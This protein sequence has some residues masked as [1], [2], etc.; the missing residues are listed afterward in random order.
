MGIKKHELKKKEN[1]GGRRHGSG[2]PKKTP[3]KTVSFRVRLEFVEPVK[4]L[5]KAAIKEWS[6][7]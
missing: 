3:T 2:Q 1:R 6:L 4:E 7:K 5:V